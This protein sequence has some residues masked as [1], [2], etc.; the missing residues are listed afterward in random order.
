MSM[1]HLLDDFCVE[2]ATALIEGDSACHR[3]AF[4]KVSNLFS[5]MEESATWQRYFH[6]DP[7]S[8]GEFGL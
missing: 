2:H 3:L 1:L 8:E 6:G 7:Q 4:W 5:R